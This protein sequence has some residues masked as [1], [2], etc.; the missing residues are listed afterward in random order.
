MKKKFIPFWLK[1]FACNSALIGCAFVI[2][3]AVTYP[4]ISSHAKGEIDKQLHEQTVQVINNLE[5][6]LDLMR[7]IYISIAVDEKLQDIFSQET[8]SSSIETLDNHDYIVQ[9]LENLSN[10]WSKTTFVYLFDNNSNLFYDSRVLSTTPLLDSSCIHHAIS[11]EGMYNFSVINDKNT[12]NTRVL[13]IGGILRKNIVGEEIGC[14]C[15]NLNLS[16]LQ[17]LIFPP[18]YTDGT[19]QLLTDSHQN[20]VIGDDITLPSDITGSESGT[21][22]LNN[23]KYLL[24][25][26]TSL[27][28]GF[29]HYILVPMDEAYREIN[30]LMNIIIL[31]IIVVIFI[32]IVIS[33]ILVKQ[34]TS[35]I[36]KL[37]TMMNCYQG[38]S[39]SRSVIQDL[40]LTNEFHVLNDGLIHMS[41]RIN[42]L[43]NDVYQHKIM[44]QQLELRTLHDA[45]NPHFIYNVLDSIQWELRLN[46]TDTALETLYTFS[47]Y[48][49]NT[50]IL[51][52]DVQTIKAMR[53]AILGYCNLQQILLD[54]IEYEINI[55]ENLDSYILPSMLVLPLVEN[56]FVHAFPGEFDRPK[57]ITAIAKSSDCELIIKIMDTGT[58]ITAADLDK[59]KLILRNPLSYQLEKDSTRFFAIKNIQSRILLN[60]GENYGME[61]E[62]D[63]MGTLV[64]LYLPLQKKD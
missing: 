10:V 33:F 27:E 43:I 46:K 6:Q 47:N 63:E 37:T 49:R 31:M 13:S 48:L 28:Y 24:Y 60:C 21:I 57:K 52:Q 26:Y 64:T 41:D 42:T 45:I 29:S 55:P 32:S 25:K 8:V 61:I 16:N 44:H 20:Y 5:Y 22:T 50:L 54:D 35:P 59:I 19:L 38:D 11:N 62:S 3:L 58:G 9:K 18:D 7:G 34:F 14:F 40:H 53:N 2:I 12:A 17:S 15:V 4:R 1:L 36:E 23:T 51:N 39:D 30:L 56:C